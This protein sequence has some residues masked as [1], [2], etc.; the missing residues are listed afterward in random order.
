MLRTTTAQNYDLWV[1]GDLKF[2]SPQVKRAFQHMDSIW[3][4]PNYVLGGREAIT[5]TFY[6][7]APVP[8]F[9]TPPSCWLH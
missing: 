7:D 6:G 8:M 4:N 5:T 2:L 9:D 1:D 3:F